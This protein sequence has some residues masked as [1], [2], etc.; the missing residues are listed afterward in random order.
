MPGPQKPTT[1]KNAAPS[2]DDPFKWHPRHEPRAT[3]GDRVR[4]IAAVA[5]F[6]GWLAFLAWM[7]TR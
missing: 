5:G 2:D 3:S 4:L 7:A 1:A 6:V